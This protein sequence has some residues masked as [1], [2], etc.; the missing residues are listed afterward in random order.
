MGRVP[1]P[2]FELPEERDPAVETPANRLMREE[3]TRMTQRFAEQIREAD[4]SG[5]CYACGHE[6]SDEDEGY[7]TCASCRR[8]GVHR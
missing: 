6:R 4:E 8:G 7:R 5:L 2:D 3:L 1:D